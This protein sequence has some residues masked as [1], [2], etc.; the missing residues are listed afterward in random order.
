MG[1]SDHKLIY[2][3]RKTSLLKPNEHHKVSFRSMK[4]YSDETFVDKLK[5]IKFP[6]YSDHTFVNYA[7]QDFVTNFLSAVDSVSPIRTSRVKS[8][9]KPWFDIDV[10]NVIQNH[11]KHYK[12]FKLSGRKTDKDY[13]KYARLSL[14][15]IIN[16]KKK[17]YFEEKIAENKNNPK[18][19]WQRRGQDNLKY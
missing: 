5:S 11:D 3:S 12:K 17:L 19:L 6:D 16:N 9:T 4:N 10:L 2:S 13:F 14:E 8:N 18:E 1:L 15:K 7:Y